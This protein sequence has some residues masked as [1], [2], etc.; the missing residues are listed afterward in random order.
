MQLFVEWVPFKEMKANTISIWVRDPKDCCLNPCINS[1]LFNILCGNVGPKMDMLACPGNAKLPQLCT[2]L[3][4]HQI[5]LVDALQCTLKGLREVYANP[6]GMQHPS[7]CT[8]GRE[9][10]RCFVFLLLLTG[11]LKHG[12]PRLFGCQSPGQNMYSFLPTDGD[13]CNLLRRMYV[14]AQ[15]ACSVSGCIKMN[16]NTYKLATSL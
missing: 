8:Y 9:I 15:K 5:H 16:K 1:K 2:T 14:Q 10:L 7:G 4:H 6:P 3:P 12:G 11:F 13:V